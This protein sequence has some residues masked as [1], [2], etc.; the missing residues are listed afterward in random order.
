[1]CLAVKIK[2]NWDQPWDH[3][4]LKLADDVFTTAMLKDV[5]EIMFTIN[6]KEKTP[7]K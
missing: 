6:L 7:E 1:M 5:K 4:M 3:L 2:G